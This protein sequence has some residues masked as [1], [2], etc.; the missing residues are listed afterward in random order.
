MPQPVTLPINPLAAA[1]PPN[2]A[3]ALTSDAPLPPVSRDPSARP[4][5][6]PRRASRCHSRMRLAV[7]ALRLWR[8]E[9]ASDL[10]DSAVA[11]QSM[12]G[13]VTLMP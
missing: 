2:V 6:G 11:V 7:V 1:A 4:I 10:R 9:A 13:S 3:A 12:H 8:T 5:I